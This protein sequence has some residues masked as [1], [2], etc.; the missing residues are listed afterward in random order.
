MKR[1]KI[2]KFKSEEEEAKFWDTHSFTNFMDELEPVHL[3]FPR[4]RHLLLTLTPADLK[5]LKQIA[6]TKDT[7]YIRL[8]QQWVREKLQKEKP[9]ISY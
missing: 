3:E 1:S 9:A 4:P 5:A 7:P 8:V 2:P 6:I